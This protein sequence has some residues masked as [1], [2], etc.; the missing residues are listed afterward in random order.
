[1]ACIYHIF[2]IHS[3]VDGHPGCFHTWLLQILPAALLWQLRK[4]GLKG[5]NNL[6]VVTPL[7]SGTAGFRLR[8]V[9][10]QS[11]LLEWD[12]FIIKQIFWHIHDISSTVTSTGEL[13][14][15]AGDSS[16]AL[17]ETLKGRTE[18]KQQ[19]LYSLLFMDRACVHS[20]WKFTEHFIF[21]IIAHTHSRPKKP[22]FLSLSSHVEHMGTRVNSLTEAGWSV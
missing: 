9:S 14:P 1:M 15:K 5:W 19:C 22:G 7:E 20:T 10:F 4:L 2:F 8:L 11:L 21:I 17:P 13:A 6:P 18:A 16:C 12:R 3:Y